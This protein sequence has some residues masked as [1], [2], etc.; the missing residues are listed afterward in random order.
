MH[1]LFF[2]QVYEENG[3]KLDTKSLMAHCFSFL[4]VRKSMKES[5]GEDADPYCVMQTTAEDW[6]N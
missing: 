4:E 1:K 6:T 3:A 2:D 5:W